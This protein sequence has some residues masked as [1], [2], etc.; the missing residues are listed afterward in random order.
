[1]TDKDKILD[2]IRKC[3]ALSA[4]SN[5][6]EAAAALRQARA[7]MEKHGIT[8][9]DVLASAAGE[10]RT[11]AGAASR[12]ALW[13]ANLAAATAAVFGC[14]SIFAG[15]VAWADHP[16]QWVFIG[17][18]ARYEVAKFC[19]EVLLRQA[20]RARAEHIKT[21]LR[22]CRPALKT[23]RADLFCHGWVASAVSKAEVLALP[24]D[25]QKALE[26]YL[27]KAY[28]SLREI[29][30]ISRNEKKSMSGT[31]WLDFARGH[32]SGASAQLN[33][34]VGANGPAPALEGA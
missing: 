15:G 33:P 26:A 1:M 28:P 24:E 4:S 10:M 25:E 12:P 6:H 22:R 3:M 19:F 29:K 7:L 18:G 21:V 32:R 11:K 9:T 23:R 31:D 30:T 5:E 34:G 27:A 20:K 8:D 13:E 17:T 14:Q 2:K 16:G